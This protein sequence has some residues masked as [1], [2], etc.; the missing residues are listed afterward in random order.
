MKV[1][2]IWY[3]RYHDNVCLIGKNH[4]T[5]G[6]N[7]IKFTK[8]RHLKGKLFAVD[9]SVIKRYPTQ[10]NGAIDVYQVPMSELVE[11]ARSTD[12]YRTVMQSNQSFRI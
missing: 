7:Y 2:D 11:V 3:P 5:Q 1:I 9:S 8:D 10:P 12:E 6:R 4:V